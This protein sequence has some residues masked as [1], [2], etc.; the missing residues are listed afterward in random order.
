M[1]HVLTKRVDYPILWG[2]L[3]ILR[4]EGVITEHLYDNET[5]H[6]EYDKQFVRKLWREL[7]EDF[8]KKCS[9]FLIR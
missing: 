8:D 9:Q 2:E 7:K 1:R 6:S 4:V 3:I 5:E